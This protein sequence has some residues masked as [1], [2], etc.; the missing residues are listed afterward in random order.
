MFHV[1]TIIAHKG[2]HSKGKPVIKFAVDD[3]L[4][5]FSYEYFKD[6]EDGI[7]CVKLTRN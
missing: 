3:Y 7:F 1:F 4:E 5:K 6:M 2:K